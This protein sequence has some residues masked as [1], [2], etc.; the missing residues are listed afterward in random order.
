MNSDS[1]PLVRF[2]VFDVDWNRDG[3][4]LLSAGGDGSVRLWDT[5]AIG[6]YGRVAKISSKRNPYKRQRLE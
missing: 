4:T 2:P 5:M 1:V 6:P 3:R